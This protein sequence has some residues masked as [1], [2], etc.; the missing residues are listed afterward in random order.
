MILGIAQGKQTSFW[1]MALYQSY[2]FSDQMQSCPKLDGYR[3]MCMYKI[4]SNIY[5][6]QVSLCPATVGRGRNLCFSLQIK[7]GC[8]Q[9]EYPSKLLKRLL[10]NSSNIPWNSHLTQDQVCQESVS[11]FFFFFSELGK[12]SPHRY[13]LAWAWIRRSHVLPFSTLIWELLYR[14]LAG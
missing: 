12:I 9:S 8:D 5:T 3:S 10:Y 7:P 13:S 2:E 1:S 11:L 4:H 6:S 14:N